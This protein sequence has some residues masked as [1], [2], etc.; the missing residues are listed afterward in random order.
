MA[1][2]FLSYDREDVA[3]AQ[4]IALALEKAG[5]SVWWDRH[6]KGGAQ[7]S[8]EI[9]QALKHADA[10]VVLWSERSVES[11][12]V[13]DEAA[14]GR[15]SNRLVPVRLDHAEPPLGFRQYQTID[16]S[17][18]GR[19]R[20]AQVQT[21]LQAVQA[22]SGSEAVD[23]I[24]SRPAPKK[25]FVNRSVL[26]TAALTLLAIAAA[27]ILWRNFGPKSSVPVVEVVGA[28]PSPRARAMA[29]EL[30][31]KL[32][33]LQ[34]A[35][36]DA[37]QLIG[38]ADH[39]DADLRFVVGGSTEG[40]VAQAS[41]LLLDGRTRDLLWSKDF[42]LPNSR[43]AD[44][45]QQVAFTAGRALDCALEALAGERTGL[46]RPVLKL[47][48][49]GCTTIDETAYRDLHQLIP[50]FRQVTAQAP[51]FEG[52]WARLVQVEV[53]AA[54]N[55]PG[56]D[57]ALMALL[58]KH[59]AEARKVNPHLAEAYLAEVELLAP[60]DHA[61]R[62]RLVELA[63]EHNPTQPD[64]FAARAHYLRFVGRM[65]ESVESAKRASELDPLSP[66]IRYDYIS[67]LTNA[68]QFDR[69]RHELEQAERLWPGASAIRSARFFLH[70]WYGDPKDAL[71]LL[72]AGA[73][74]ASPQLTESFLRARIDPTPA[75]IEAA[76]RQARA[77]LRRDPTTISVLAQVLGV[78]DREEELFSLLLDHRG[79]INAR[80]VFS[81]ALFRPALRDLR[82]DPRFMRVAKRLGLMAYWQ[83]SGKWPD[84]CFE[85]DLPYDCKKEAAKLSA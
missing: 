42:E 41:L 85:P 7:Y 8:K 23:D 27:F 64:P 6:I 24:A 3:K 5:Y 51:R 70:H 84:F 1:S 37:V 25:Q 26:M 50:T 74:S 33:H 22:L 78:F 54:A 65:N 44:L 35:K 56:G 77:D 62:L 57:P 82:R 76:V 21:L 60:T 68:G 66:V 10:V 61:A 69:A 18:T 81:V 38:Q 58:K 29:H 75:Y 59:I 48:L 14:A 9:E 73:A 55:S 34:S 32:G 46:T 79:T 11:T 67:A 17:R 80:D 49:N 13:R 12:W 45:Q 36:A 72:R 31:A 71:Q 28:D 47:Y 20:N 43:Q 19:G 2:V 52:G 83:K 16:M 39:G 30:L 63:V 40:Q 53:F 4:T 15:D